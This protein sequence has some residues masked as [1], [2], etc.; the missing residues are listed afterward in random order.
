MY[1]LLSNYFV[2][3]IA[4]CIVLSCNKPK[5]KFVNDQTG[6][7]NVK[8]FLSAGEI[9]SAFSDV[10]VPTFF[11]LAKVETESKIDINSIVLGE[12]KSKGVKLSVHPVALLSFN[13][14]TI[15][16]K[17]VVSIDSENLKI[18]HEYN[19]FLLNNYN[20]QATIENWFKSQ[21]I[22]RGCDNFKWDNAYKAFLEVK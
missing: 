2:V 1:K 15:I 12:K 13:Q 14:D 4:F 9:Y 11:N 16:H 7:L 17:F 20:M 3:F 19:S 21:S 6:T 10:D 8:V 22:D 5:A 18:E